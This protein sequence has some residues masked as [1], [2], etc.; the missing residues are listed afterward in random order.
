[1]IL[2]AR[3]IEVLWA[4]RFVKLPLIGINNFILPVFKKAVTAKTQSITKGYHV[5]MVLP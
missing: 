5:T 4:S 3:L 2:V 1:M